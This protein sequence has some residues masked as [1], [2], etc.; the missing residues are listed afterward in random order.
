[1]KKLLAVI[2]GIILPVFS[3]A[4]QSIFDVSSENS[5][6]KFVEI[7]KNAQDSVYD[8]IILS[9][10]RYLTK[11]RV[12]NS[13]FIEKCKFIENAFFDEEEYFNPK[14]FEFEEC[15][16][17][18]I[19]HF[20]DDPTSIIYYNYDKYTDSSVVAIEELLDDISLG[21][22][23]E[24]PD[25]IWMAY[26]KLTYHYS[27]KEGFFGKTVAL[28]YDAMSK[29][30][31]L[32]LSVLMANQYKDAGEEEKAVDVLL[33]NMD[34]TVSYGSFYSKGELFFELK[35]YENAYKA[36]NWSL[37]KEEGWDLSAELGAVLVK[38]ERYDEARSFLLEASD[39]E[40][41]KR[42]ALEELLKYDLQYSSKDTS[43]VSY[44]NMRAEGFLSDP[45]GVY[46][47]K[48]LYKKKVL[49]LGFS[50]LLPIISFIGLL[51]LVLLIPYLWI[52]PIYSFGKWKDTYT[53]ENIFLDR[54][55][56]KHFWYFCSLFLFASIF[57]EIIIDYSE[58]LVTFNGEYSDGL[59]PDGLQLAKFILLFDFIMIV[60]TLAILRF[61][62]LKT[63]LGQKHSLGHQ[64]L[65]GITA[66]IV[67]RIMYGIVEQIFQGMMG[68]PQAGLT[69]SM[70]NTGIAGM[71]EHYG[72]LLPFILIV[73]TGP[74]LEE[75]QFRGIILGSV[76]KYIPF[77]AAN[78]IQSILFVLVHE[79]LSLFL[80]YF[81]FGI[82]TGFLR[83]STG[84]YI[85]PMVLH[86]INNGIVFIVIALS[87]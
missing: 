84:G 16:D 81:T 7:V 80:F 59:P 33:Q 55:Q 82:A 78:T 4:Q 83:K 51:L 45:F 50:D 31:E 39:T 30:P 69:A 63:F 13:V 32:D 64:V 24:E 3:M 85:A 58:M 76:S 43:V 46:R 65:T 27:D 15:L 10:D 52:L 6:E 86:I 77:W 70:L 36:Y 29:N 61:K 25:N 22:I 34:S 87:L 72:L 41:G 74:I 23:E 48:L 73:V 47:I 62:D 75:I 66:F 21:I 5:S 67:F 12:D 53:N 2:I 28:A 40:W 8:S 49:W 71:I 20:P 44:T 9:Y 11:N 60:G 38:L 1:M 26:E 68:A 19:L 17:E 35:D 79:E 57:T 14:Y 56:I 18:L 37:E 54:W 42:K